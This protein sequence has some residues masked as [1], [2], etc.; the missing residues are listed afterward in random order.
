MAQWYYKG[1]TTTPIEHPELGSIV[2]RPRQRFEAPK[3]SVQHL[4]SAG[5]CSRLPDVQPA[6]QTVVEEK[7]APDPVPEVT[8]EADKKSDEGLAEKV[9]PEATDNKPEAEE[10]VVDADEQPAPKRRRGRK[11]RS[12]QEGS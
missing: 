10:V 2:I 1:R 3:S 4:L 9:E 12:S 6:A 5:L 7:P 11:G 8:A